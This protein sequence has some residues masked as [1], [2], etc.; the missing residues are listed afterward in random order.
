MV[1]RPSGEVA[2]TWGLGPPIR[3]H[4]GRPNLQVTAFFAIPLGGVLIGVDWLELSRQELGWQQLAPLDLVGG[5]LVVGLAWLMIALA[6]AAAVRVGSGGISVSVRRILGGRERAVSWIEWGDVVLS[7]PGLG[8]KFARTVQL[9]SKRYPLNTWAIDYPQARA[10]LDHPASRVAFASFPPWLTD[11]LGVSPARVSAN[12]LQNPQPEA[13][14]AGGAPLPGRT[15]RTGET[16]IDITEPPKSSDEQ[17]RE[18]RRGGILSAAFYSFTILFTL[19]ISY[20]VLVASLVF[21]LAYVAMMAG[22][23]GLYLWQWRL[24][25]RRGAKNEDL[26]DIVLKNSRVGSDAQTLF[27]EDFSGRREIPWTRVGIPTLARPIG[28]AR[29][30]LPYTDGEGR[31]KRLRMTASRLDAVLRLPDR[32]LWQLAPETE[33]ALRI[34]LSRLGRAPAVRTD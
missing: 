32:P 14:R 34:D 33:E 19:W 6:N 4:F 2:Q 24:K 9:G 16:W 29:F 18:T 27:L 22:F 20:S 3:G 25:A 31:P 23:G 17:R 7:V 28:R 12:S 13:S 30:S 1:D 8:P 15:D 5:V 21:T 26:A 10:V 11:R